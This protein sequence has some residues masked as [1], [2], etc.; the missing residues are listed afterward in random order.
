MSENE[1]SSFFIIRINNVENNPDEDSRSK[2]KS[3]CDNTTD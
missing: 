1:L 2:T 3:S